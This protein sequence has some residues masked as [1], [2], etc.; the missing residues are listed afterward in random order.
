MKNFFSGKFL[1]SNRFSHKI[2][3]RKNLYYGE[4]SY[5]ASSFM[6]TSFSL[7]N[8]KNI[9]ITLVSKTMIFVLNT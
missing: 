3:Q 4:I 2:K 9:T 6:L 1:S 8:L 5:I 7:F